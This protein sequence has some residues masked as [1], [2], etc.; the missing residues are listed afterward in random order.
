MGIEN[1]TAANRT[2]GESPALLGL[3][4]TNLI[5]ADLAQVR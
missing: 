3:I 2:S 5:F 4:G 1:T